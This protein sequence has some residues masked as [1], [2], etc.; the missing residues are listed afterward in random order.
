LHIHIQPVYSVHCF[1]EG[2]DKRAA[3]LGNC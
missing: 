2:N 3:V 1:V